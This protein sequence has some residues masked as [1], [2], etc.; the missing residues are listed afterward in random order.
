[1]DKFKPN[2]E[3]TSTPTSFSGT[4]T[5]EYADKAESY[6]N[7][8][9]PPDDQF[10]LNVLAFYE[11]TSGVESDLPV[12]LDHNGLLAAVL[13]SYH[14]GD[15]FTNSIK[16]EAL[17]IPNGSWGTIHIDY[18]GMNTPWFKTDITIEKCQGF[19][20]L[21]IDNKR[22]KN[23]ANER[24]RTALQTG[25][26]MV[27]ARI[28]M[29]FNPVDC[30]W[31]NIDLSDALSRLKMPEGAYPK[32]AR[33]LSGEQD[34]DLNV[35]YPFTYDGHKF[36]A[37]FSMFNSPGYHEL[38]EGKSIWDGYYHQARGPNV[39]GASWDKQGEPAFSKL[40]IC[41]GF[42][43]AEDMGRLVDPKDQFT[44]RHARDFLYDRLLTIKLN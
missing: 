30:W 22:G 8:V 43:K 9:I 7:L 4:S 10:L 25:R 3:F 29:F 14:P 18:E 1:M 41:F 6:R 31:Y 5:L 44:L 28:D 40:E 19:Y 17:S 32:L 34:L 42:A 23:D 33:W 27:T 39:V 11:A 21:N 35:Q 26:E 36:E 15:T 16:Q 37:G 12:G 13:G 2:H 38:I 20:L 24:L